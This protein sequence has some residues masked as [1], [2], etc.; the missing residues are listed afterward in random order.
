MVENYR[1]YA[2][3]LREQFEGEKA[4]MIADRNRL[5]ELM[6]EERVLWEEERALFKRKIEEMEAILSQMP[7]V[8]SREVGNQRYRNASHPRISSLS[9]HGGSVDSTAHSVPQESGRNADGT[10]FYAPAPRKPS[11][12][13]DTSHGAEMRVDDIQAPRDTPIRVT[14]R[15]L[16]SSDFFQSPPTSNSHTEQLNTIQETA[17]ETIDIQLIQPELEGVAIKASAVT[18]AFAAKV[19]SPRRSPPKFSPETKAPGRDVTN[20]ERRFSPEDKHKMTLE[21][22]NQPE[23]RRLTMHAGH[24]PSHSM[25]FPNLEGIANESG[26]ATPTQEHHNE[27]DP[28]DEHIHRPSVAGPALGDLH[29]HHA[30]EHLPV[31]PEEVDETRD[32]INHDAGEDDKPLTGPLGLTNIAT[33]DTLFLDQLN[34]KLEVV[35]RKS[36]DSSPSQASEERSLSPVL[37]RRLSSGEEDDDDEKDEVEAPRLRIKPS[38]NFGRPM[39]SM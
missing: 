22:A 34:K 31:L 12:T 16:T 1:S 36:R 13:F 35:A 32:E 7:S 24:T 26:S 19:L 30:V 28:K 33:K 11:R 2:V 15:E 4:H 6:E 5:E 27:L 37:T 21:I 39:G 25:C 3:R 20:V 8:F 14:S 9:S 29:Q 17:G 10:P 38:L 18:P 23:N